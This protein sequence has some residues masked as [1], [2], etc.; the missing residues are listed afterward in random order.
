MNPDPVIRLTT[1]PEHERLFRGLYALG[2]RFCGTT[3]VEE[4]WIHWR[5]CVVKHDGRVT[6]DHVT[7][8]D[9][10]T[11][12][13]ANTEPFRDPTTPMNSIPHF[14]AYTRRLKAAPSA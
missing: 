7:V 12:L 5:G 9:R 2:A 11:R 10:G 3:D 6:H 1:L 4:A 14:L 13:N 8:Y